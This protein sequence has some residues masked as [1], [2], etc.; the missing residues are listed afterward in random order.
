[1]LLHNMYLSHI[2]GLVTSETF[3]AI[4][5]L[6]TLG[7]VNTWMFLFCRDL[8]NN[9]LTQEIPDSVGSLQHLEVL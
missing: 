3:L 5:Q 9:R 6:Y 7:V 2:S 1:M 8:S 4:A